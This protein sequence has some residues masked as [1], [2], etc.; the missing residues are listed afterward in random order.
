MT[1]ESPV[2]AVLIILPIVDGCPLLASKLR[3]CVAQSGAAP[4]G[5]NRRRICE[6][7]SLPFP[8]T[9]RRT[10]ECRADIQRQ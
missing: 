2:Q 6:L 5:R 9:R 10:P 1:W 8:P 7:R 3:N 4:A